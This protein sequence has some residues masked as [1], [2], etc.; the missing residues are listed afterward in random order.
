MDSY[1]F[2]EECYDDAD[3]QYNA[4]NHARG[5]E[6]DNH[7]FRSLIKPVNR[8]LI[9]TIN[10]SFIICTAPPVVGHIDN[11]VFVHTLRNMFEVTVNCKVLKSKVGTWLTT[12]QSFK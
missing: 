4:N 10:W 1:I 3:V 7:F 5:I 6:A 9:L 12:Q 8:I 11:D 2:G